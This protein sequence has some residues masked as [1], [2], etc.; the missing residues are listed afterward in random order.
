MGNNFVHL[1]NNSITKDHKEFHDKVRIS[2]FTLFKCFLI[3]FFFFFLLLILG[4]NSVK[5]LLFRLQ[6]GQYFYLLIL[7]LFEC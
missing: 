4:Q 7:S 1:V 3:H 6:S 5:E 2:V